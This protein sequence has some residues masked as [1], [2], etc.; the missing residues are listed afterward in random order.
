MCTLRMNTLPERLLAAGVSVASEAEA[1]S[2]IEFAE[3]FA[4][5]VIS[6]KSA[7]DCV[8]SVS[9]KAESATEMEVS[10]IVVT[11]RMGFSVIS[12]VL[13]ESTVVPAAG[14]TI[15]A[16]LTVSALKFGI[17][18]RTVASCV[19]LTVD[20]AASVLAASAATTN[21]TDEVVDDS[22]LGAEL[23]SACSNCASTAGK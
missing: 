18:V 1:E 17:L 16:G 9:E 7:A 4:E 8:T 14:I 5:W 13:N 6:D 10:K 15:K 23:V 2:P 21:S 3:S 19:S 12:T 22:F 11:T 20:C